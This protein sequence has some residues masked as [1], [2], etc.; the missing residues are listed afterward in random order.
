MSFNKYL[1][2]NNSA[3]DPEFLEEYHNMFD[4]KHE[5]GTF[6][7]NSENVRN[8]L[9][10]SGKTRFN[11][12][13]TTNYREFVDYITERIDT[14]GIHGCHKKQKIL[15]TPETAK[16]ICM[17]S[18]SPRAIQFQKY[19]L[20][21][22]KECFKLV[23]TGINI[24]FIS[25]DEL[26]GMDTPPRSFIHREFALY[27]ENGNIKHNDGDIQ[28]YVTENNF[29]EVIISKINL[30]SRGTTSLMLIKY[31]PEL[32][33]YDVANTVLDKI[34]YD[35]HYRK[36][37]KPYH[38]D[39]II[40]NSYQKEYSSEWTVDVEKRTNY[41]GRVWMTFSREN[42]KYVSIN[43]CDE[44]Y[45]NFNPEKPDNSEPDFP[46]VIRGEINA[47]GIFT[48]DY[49][50]VDVNCTIETYMESRGQMDYYYKLY[51]LYYK[52]ENDK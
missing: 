42:I 18:R 45:H 8:F 20:E 5:E 40:N 22:E 44:T 7:I 39:L 19:F 35:L 25:V 16:H 51:N 34:S 50:I 32:D 29:L 48:Y 24:G 31:A 10:L 28:I 6:V 4:E 41:G 3:I 37:D 17:T 13:I 11:I 47:D 23:Q 27:K 49:P 1:K 52:E 12:N 33:L 26:P 46:L 14:T 30:F 9:Q 36:N 21:V 43:E 38:R 2:D 15:L